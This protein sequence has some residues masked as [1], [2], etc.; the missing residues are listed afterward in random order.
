MITDSQAKAGPFVGDGVTTEYDFA[1]P[2]LSADH[3]AVYVDEVKITSG[4][5]AALLPGGG[6]VTL[7][8]PLP[9][10]ARGHRDRPGPP[11][12]GL[13]ATPGKPFPGGH[14]APDG[15]RADMG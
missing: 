6:R 3:I 10:G 5:T 2:A 4:Y 8:E 13:P 1:F 12:H 14:R 7:D 15:Y 11:H 9:E